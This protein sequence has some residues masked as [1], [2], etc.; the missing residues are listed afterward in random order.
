MRIGIPSKYA[1]VLN[2]ELLK[3]GL[4]TELECWDGHKHIDI[5]IPSARLYIE[6]DGKEHFTNPATIE[7]DFKRTHYSDKS[8]FNTFH[9]PNLFIKHHC[10]VLAK[11]IERLVR[12]RESIK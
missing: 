5:A 9:I 6:I 7:R 3:R 1:I 12:N 10:K 2:N 11:G 8:N 4:H